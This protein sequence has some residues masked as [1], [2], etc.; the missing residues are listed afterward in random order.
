MFMSF[1]DPSTWV[2]TLR[3]R[4][5]VLAMK[6]KGDLAIRKDQKWC[7]TS[8][9]DGLTY[10]YVLPFGVYRIHKDGISIL[11]VMIGRLIF[12]FAWEDAA[13]LSKS[14]KGG[15]DGSTDSSSTSRDS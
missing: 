9:E 12:T 4:F 15:H 10:T 8:T 11:G 5:P 1:I 7:I 14:E 13:L 3:A 6:F 2:S